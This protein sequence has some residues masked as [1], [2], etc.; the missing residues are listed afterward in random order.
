[1]RDTH[2]NILFFCT[3]VGQIDSRHEAGAGE[4]CAGG[5]AEQ[6]RGAGQDG[7]RQGGGGRQELRLRL[8][9]GEGRAEG[10]GETRIQV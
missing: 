2:L 4:V 6:P 8:R 1:M 3:S 5:A 9:G 10:A 7:L